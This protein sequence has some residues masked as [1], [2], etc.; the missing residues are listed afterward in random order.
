MINARKQRVLAIAALCFLIILFVSV[1]NTGDK[2]PQLL[3]GERSYSPTPGNNKLAQ[4]GGNVNQ[5][6]KDKS[7]VIDESKV[8]QAEE[9]SSVKPP[10]KAP[11]GDSSQKKI[12]ADTSKKA[13]SA[14]ENLAIKDQK[15][16]ADTKEQKLADSKDSLGNSVAKDETKADIQRSNVDSKK[17][18]DSDVKK[19]ADH[20]DSAGF[21]AAKEFKEILSLSPVAIFSKSYCPYSKKLK[22]LLQTSYDITPQPTV[23]ELDLHK[24]GKELQDYIASVSGRRTVPNLFVNGVSRGGSDE[25]SALHADNKLLDQLTAWGGP[26]VKVEKINKPSNS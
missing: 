15:G 24:H 16:P 14:K 22:D 7:G 21:D 25:M 5:L 23:V 20:E 11:S 2:K 13:G 1:T 18:A 8:K 3:A 12:T 9:F 10:V 4:A 26:K 6:V 17:L 19:V